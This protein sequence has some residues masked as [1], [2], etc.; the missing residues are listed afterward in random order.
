MSEIGLDAQALESDHGLVIRYCD[1]A[2]LCHVTGGVCHMTSAHC[3][4]GSS[5]DT[6]KPPNLEQR[7]WVQTTSDLRAAVAM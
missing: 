2:R 5:S 4:L 7:P 3:S 6:W 1:I